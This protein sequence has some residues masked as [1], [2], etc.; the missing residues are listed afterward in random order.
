MVSEY[1]CVFGISPKTPELVPG[2]T[3]RTF[4]EGYSFLT[5]SSKE[6]RV[7]WFFF[8]KMARKYSSH[9]IPRFNPEDVDKHV[10]PWLHKPLSGSV[11]FRD[12]YETALVKTHLAL[13]EASFKHWSNGRIVCIGDSI[14]K[15]C[16]LNIGKSCAV[17]ETNC[18]IFFR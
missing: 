3:H 17:T 9:E 14:H 13:E 1:D 15:V 12:V 18:C 8:A 16:L 10:A 11:C 7:Y 4:G 6:G 5:I 2:H